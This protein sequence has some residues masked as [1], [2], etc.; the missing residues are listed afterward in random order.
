MAVTTLRYQTY[1]APRSH[2]VAVCWSLVFAAIPVF[3]SYDDVN[4]G[5]QTKIRRRTSIFIGC[6]LVRAMELENIYV[7]ARI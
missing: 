3:V 2:H 1:T 4:V 6:K 7:I 5:S